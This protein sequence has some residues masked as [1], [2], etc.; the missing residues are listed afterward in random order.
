[1]Y[2]RWR[3]EGEVTSFNGWCKTL[4]LA[5]LMADY[6]ATQE[7]IPVDDIGEENGGPDFGD[8]GTS[9]A[10]PEVTADISTFNASGR[11][12]HLLYCLYHNNS[13]HTQA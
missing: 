3:G 13:S 6:L 12:V 11:P 2:S 4:Q 10:P 8:D 9:Q 1:M 7:A 5:Y